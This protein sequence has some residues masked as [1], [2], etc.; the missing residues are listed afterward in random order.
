MKSRRCFASICRPSISIRGGAAGRRSRR[1]SVLRRFVSRSDAGRAP[2]TAYA[3]YSR[4]RRALWLARPG[5]CS[6]RPRAFGCREHA[7][8]GRLAERRSRDRESSARTGAGKSTIAA[9]AFARWLGALPSRWRTRFTPARPAALVR[10]RWCRALLLPLF[11]AACPALAR[12]LPHHFRSKWKSD[13]AANARPSRGSAIVACF[14]LY[15]LRAHHARARRRKAACL[16]RGSPAPAARGALVVS[17]RYPT[18]QRG[19]SGRTGAVVSCSTIAMPSTA[20]AR[21]RRGNARIGAIPSADLV[22][23]LELPAELALPSQ[24]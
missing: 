4:R 17:D 1:E 15:P 20:L 6:G 11:A 22:L 5:A 2:C 7:P 16:L 3:R 24:T 23:H 13:E 19:G 21:A 14:F 12:R 9:G 10:C 18:L 8:A